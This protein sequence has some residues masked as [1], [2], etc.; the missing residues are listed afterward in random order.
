MFEFCLKLVSIY[1]YCLHIKF[2]FAFL[3]TKLLKIPFENVVKWPLASWMLTCLI[4][5]NAYSGLFYSLLTLRESETP[6]DTIEQFLEYI[7]AN[8]KVEFMSNAYT[9]QLILQANPQENELY[10]KI[11]RRFNK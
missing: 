3:A 2:I 1:F 10:Y 9:D 5:A 11:G 6:I 4:L 8:K 7:T